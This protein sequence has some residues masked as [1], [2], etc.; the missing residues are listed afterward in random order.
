MVEPVWGWERRHG[1]ERAGSAPEPGATATAD[2]GIVLVEAAR[3]VVAAM[4]KASMALRS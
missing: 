4:S 1:V 3:S 2:A